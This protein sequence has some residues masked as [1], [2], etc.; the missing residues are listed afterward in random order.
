LPRH[1]GPSD[2]GLYSFAESL[3]ATAM[4]CLSLG[5]DSYTLRELP[6][7]PGHAS[8]YFGGTVVLRSLL[9]VLMVAGL[10][11]ML[12]GRGATTARVA[13]VFAIGYLIAGV[14]QL[15]AACL[16]ANATV[17]RLAVVNVASKLVWGAAIVAALSFGAP[18]E[19]L[20]ASFVL[21]ESLKLALLYRESRARLGLS[22]RIDAAATIAVA[23]ASLPYFANSVALNLNR[24]DIAVL[25]F[26]AG[27]EV[28]GWYGA[29]GNFSLLV[30]LLLPLMASVV[31]PLLARV[32]ARSE[33]EFLRVMGRLTQGLIIFT[34]PLA[35][36]VALGADLWVRIAFGEAFLPAAVSLRVMAPL[37]LLTYV[38]SL[39]SMALL[40]LDR[41]W[42]VT[43]TSVIGLVVN[44]L[45]CVL[46]IPV[47]ARLFGPGGA[48]AGA[49]LGV[50][51]MELTIIGLQL[52]SVGLRVLG[53]RALPV[54][55]RCLLASVLALTLHLLTAR[56]GH[57][58]LVLDAAAYLVA[59][60][61]LGVFPVRQLGDL[62]RE[63]LNARR[64]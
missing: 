39:L 24:L 45:L 23:V 4:A 8:D 2:F 48:G 60:R 5:I 33:D 28:V 46:L 63:V 1:L 30:F 42:T 6:T 47:G 9:G 20:A 10:A 16:Q 25:G 36:M 32:R 37:S 57:F 13:A 11:V 61:A 12:T 44:P 14:A 51:G 62:A 64:D 56:F 19:L 59:A 18:L 43:F 55:S 58:R 27:A 35:L 52:R 38:A 31:L 7:R 54:A 40:T 41:R 53:P 34:T 3:A 22:F 21:G 50:V 17:A 26:M 15:L 49:A 29:A